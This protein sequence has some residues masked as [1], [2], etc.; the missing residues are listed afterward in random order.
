MISTPHF[1]ENILD[2]K[3]NLEQ[4]YSVG[5]FTPYSYI[6]ISQEDGF[7]IFDIFDKKYTIT[8]EYDIMNEEAFK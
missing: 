8:V 6:N 7:D 4:I 3:F 2:G 1:Q 5:V